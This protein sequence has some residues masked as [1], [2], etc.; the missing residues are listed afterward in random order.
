V[1]HTSHS[2][3]QNEVTNVA[4]ENVSKCRH[5]TSAHAAIPSAA[6]RKVD[7]R[8]TTSATIAST[9]APHAIAA[10]A[11]CTSTPGSPR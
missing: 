10:S 11:G 7:A 1:N 5:A 2:A 6:A 9:G 8:G 3:T 4:S